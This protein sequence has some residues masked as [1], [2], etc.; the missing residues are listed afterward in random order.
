MPMSN[1]ERY[2]IF[3]GLLSQA[4]SGLFAIGPQSLRAPGTLMMGYPRCITMSHLFPL[5]IVHRIVARTSPELE[6]LPVEAEE[7]AAVDWSHPRKRDSSSELPQAA[8]TFLRH[9]H[10]LSSP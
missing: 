2:S 7:L 10:F 4:S 1:L 8:A 5:C 3:L 6:D 9:P